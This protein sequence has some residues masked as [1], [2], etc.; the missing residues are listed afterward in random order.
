MSDSVDTKRLLTIV[1]RTERLMEEQQG[2]ATDIKDI[3]AEAKSAGLDPK[4]IK[5]AIRE[6]AED[7]EKRRLGE[8]EYQLY[9]DA[10]GIE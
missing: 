4:Y 5:R 6:R 3:M 10:L 1:E 9:R 7:G 2:L 8:A